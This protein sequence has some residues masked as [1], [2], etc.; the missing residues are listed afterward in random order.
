MART[1]TEDPGTFGFVATVIVFI[2]D[3]TSKLMV[4]HVRACQIT[5]AYLQTLRVN[6]QRRR[7]WPCI[8]DNHGIIG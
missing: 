5:W 4:L 3:A 2:D 8:R 6:R 7:R 1:I